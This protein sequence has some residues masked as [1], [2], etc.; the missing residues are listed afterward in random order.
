MFSGI[1]IKKK[2]DIEELNKEGEIAIDLTNAYKSHH[3]YWDTGDDGSS[4]SLPN[5]LAL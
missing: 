3:L 4:I 1:W 2:G 5:G